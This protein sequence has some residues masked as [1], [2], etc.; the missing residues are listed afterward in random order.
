MAEKLPGGVVLHYSVKQVL[1]KD[2]QNV[3]ILQ[4]IKHEVANVIE[5]PVLDD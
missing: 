5:I 3:F 1:F 4:N 2:I